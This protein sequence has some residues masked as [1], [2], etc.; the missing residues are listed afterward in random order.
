MKKIKFWG[1]VAIFTLLSTSVFALKIEDITKD[2]VDNFNSQADEISNGFDD[3]S[4]QL[5]AAVP[6]AATQQNVWS[7]AY[8]GQLISLPP[9]LGGGVNIGFTHI[10]KS[11][12]AKL[13]S[14]TTLTLRAAIISRFLRLIFVLAEFC[15]LSILTLLL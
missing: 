7:N 10:D 4:K 9:N 15:F 5:A 3:F 6:Q 12:L 1:S 13:C 14:L 11:R 2:W 8:I